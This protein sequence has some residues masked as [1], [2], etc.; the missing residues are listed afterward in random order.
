MSHCVNMSCQADINEIDVDGNYEIDT[1]KQGAQM[2]LTMD[3]P[4]RLKLKLHPNEKI[5]IKWGK[6]NHS[7]RSQSKKTETSE[8]LAVCKE[9]GVEGLNYFEK[10]L[11]KPSKKSFLPKIVPKQAK[12]VNTTGKLRPLIRSP[13]REPLSNNLQITT[14][15]KYSYFVISNYSN[16]EQTPGL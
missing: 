1:W 3:K 9:I 8:N 14:R 15:R 11:E 12:K 16:Y 13:Y 7:M 10:E 2:V 6:K 5:R 4:N